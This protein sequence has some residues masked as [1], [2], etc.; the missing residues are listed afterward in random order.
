MPTAARSLENLT[1][2]EPLSPEFRDAKLIDANL[3]TNDP[4]LD[5]VLRRLLGAPDVDP[6]KTRGP[7]ESPSPLERGLKALLANILKHTTPRYLAL[8]KSWSDYPAPSRYCRSPLSLSAIIA[9]TEFLRDRGWIQIHPGS[10]A[11]GLRTRIEVTEDFKAILQRESLT[12]Q[13]TI[14]LTPPEESIVLRNEAGAL[15]DYADTRRSC[16]FRR[17]L[18]RIN[19]FMANHT[20]HHRGRRL[21]T[22]LV[23]I[24][25]NSFL[26][27]GRFYR[28]EHLA[29]K[30]RERAEL[31]LDHQPVVE[32]DFACMHINMLYIRETGKAYAGDAYQTESPHIPRE[33]FKIILQII[34]NCQSRFGAVLAANKA[35]KERGLQTISAESA[36]SIFLRKHQAIAKY[37]FSGIGVRLQYEDS[38]IAERVLLS[39]VRDGI[40]IL[41]VHDSFLVSVQNEAWLQNAMDEACIAILGSVVP[42]KTKRPPSNSESGPKAA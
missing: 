22:H 10:K 8:S 31:T 28:A 12:S 40:A 33:V 17:D 26:E 41:P 29:L 38:L 14:A 42:V 34:L 25:K 18:A 2:N 23:R 4:Q 30:S 1:T 35:L 5:T 32:V 6:V 27:G 7:A 21:S 15:I 37:F 24:F 19:S 11:S 9:A 3:E 36:I 39:A 20:V 13:T 16:E